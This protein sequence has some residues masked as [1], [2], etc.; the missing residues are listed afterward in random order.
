MNK[1]VKTHMLRP[2]V[3]DFVITGIVVLAAGLWLFFL[4][5]GR[6]PGG[7]AV[8][9]TP[10]GERTI[11]L[12]TDAVYEIE[13]NNRIH[14]VLRVKNGAIFFE[15][16]ECPDH[17]CVKSGQL[18]RSG[19]TAACVPAGVLVRVIGKDSGMDAVVY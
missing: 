4:V 17:I 14:V 19:Q 16:S 13:G 5:S 2:T 11:L 8:V 12:S 7:S 6:E 3:W 9:T 15:S 1:P 18:T 10:Q